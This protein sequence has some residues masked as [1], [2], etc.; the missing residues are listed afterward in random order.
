MRRAVLASC[1]RHGAILAQ[2]P[3]ANNSADTNSRPAHRPIR[4]VK[5]KERDPTPPPPA[6]PPLQPA[7]EIQQASATI[8]DLNW[9]LH[10][11]FAIHNKLLDRIQQDRGKKDAAQQASRDKLKTHD[12]APMLPELWTPEMRKAIQSNKF[13][14]E[15][16]MHN[17]MRTRSW[18]RHT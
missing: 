6:A 2:V 18:P 11:G 1:G 5:A 4:L 10:A 14:P 9:E 16:K 7:Q 8:E 12:S 3:D 15:N 17:T 13:C